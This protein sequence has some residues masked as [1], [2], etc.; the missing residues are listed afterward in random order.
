MLGLNNIAVCSEFKA[1][2]SSGRLKH[3]ATNLKASQMTSA[4]V[5]IKCGTK[6][7]LMVEVC[8]EVQAARGP[9]SWGL[10]GGES[11]IMH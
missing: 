1:K 6:C 7:L 5:C 4:F 10:L 11:T 3:F 2:V 8:A 9:M